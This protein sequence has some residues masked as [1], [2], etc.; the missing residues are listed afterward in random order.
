ME[1]TAKAKQRLPI[2]EGPRYPDGTFFIRDTD[3]NVWDGKRWRG[4]G[5]A[6]LFSNFR[7]A[8]IEAFKAKS[9]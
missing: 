7:G 3:N 4:F 5:M 2:I 1:K 8:F 6:K 9:K